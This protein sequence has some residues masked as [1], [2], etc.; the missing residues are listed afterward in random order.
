MAP[1]E[2]FAFASQQGL[3]FEYFLRR[4]VIPDARPHE[5]KRPRRSAEVAIFLDR[6]GCVHVRLFWNRFKLI[7][8]TLRAHSPAA[9]MVVRWALRCLSSCPRPE[10][11]GPHFG[12]RSIA[13]RRDAS[14]QHRRKGIRARWRFSRRSLEGS[15]A[16]L[17][18]PGAKNA[19]RDAEGRTIRHIF[20]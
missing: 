8:L 1:T 3:C 12:R 19:P 14:P 17:R 7:W 18:Y 16:R 2:F 6:A 15:S 13:A 11:S 10:E 9:V 4:R 5:P 20:G